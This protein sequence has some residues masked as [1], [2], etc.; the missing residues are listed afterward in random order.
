[1]DTPY[2]LNL[3][4]WDAEPWSNDHFA[5]VLRQ[6]SAA[7]NSQRFVL[8]MMVAPKDIGRFTDL[9]EKDGYTHVMPLYWCKEHVFLPGQIDKYASCVET[10]LV[11]E[12]GV[13]AVGT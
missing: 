10:L 5:K 12:R 7:N 3:A 13:A 1:M 9:L 8:M 11:A 4:P 6:V 2:G